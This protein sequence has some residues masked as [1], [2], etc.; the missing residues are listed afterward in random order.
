VDTEIT[1][2]NPSGKLTDERLAAFP[3]LYVK[4]NYNAQQACIDLGMKRA[5][6]K[7]HAYEYLRAV[8]LRVSMQ[9]ALK[10]AKLDPTRLARK[11]NRLMEAKEPKWNQ[12]TKTWDA[13]ENTTAQL[14]AIKQTARLLNLYP[15][16]PKEGDGSTVNVI[17]DVKL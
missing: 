9:D 15:A 11:L 3:N 2:V 17:I 4:N 5:T 13:F 16:E 1:K 8:R 7:A 6:A 10:R 12:A 14:E